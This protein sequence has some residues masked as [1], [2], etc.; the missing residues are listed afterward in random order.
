MDRCI[1]PH[2]ATQGNSRVP[3]ARIIGRRALGATGARTTLGDIGD[4]PASEE[5]GQGGTRTWTKLS[6]PASKGLVSSAQDHSRFGSRIIVLLSQGAIQLM[7]YGAGDRHHPCDPTSAT[8]CRS[9]RQAAAPAARVEWCALVVV[10]PQVRA[11]GR[12]GRRPRPAPARSSTA[13]RRGQAWRL[14]GPRRRAPPI[15][16][17]RAILRR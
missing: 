6:P 17:G 12:R 15:A 2:R 10:A 8:D 9:A 13:D 14:R 11:G 3:A 4:V 5:S 7:A 16:A 1:E